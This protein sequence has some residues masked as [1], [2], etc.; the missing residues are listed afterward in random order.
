MLRSKIEKLLLA[1]VQW[2]QKFLVSEYSV[3]VQLT[4]LV[5]GLLILL[6]FYLLRSKIAGM[7]FPIVAFCVRAV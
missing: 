3:A 6:T 1:C 5:I 4:A 2:A 7:F